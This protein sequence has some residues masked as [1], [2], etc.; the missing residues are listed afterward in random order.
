MKSKGYIK[1]IEIEGSTNA[2]NTVKMVEWR[3]T[4]NLVG[5]T[6][7][8]GICIFVPEGVSI[9]V[10]KFDPKVYNFYHKGHK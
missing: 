8:K 7:T 5:K 1:V 10:E 3:T 4:Q 9:T 6:T 2:M